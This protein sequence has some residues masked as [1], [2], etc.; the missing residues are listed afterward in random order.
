MGL[1]DSYI[2]ILLI[3]VHITIVANQSENRKKFLR[4]TVSSEKY[5]SGYIF[6]STFLQ[7]GKGKRVVG[8]TKE[9]LNVPSRSRAK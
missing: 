3:S 2:Y 4:F 8:I 1:F 7:Q 6:V 9:V 5:V